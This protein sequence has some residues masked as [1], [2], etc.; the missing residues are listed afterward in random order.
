MIT[1]IQFP[2]GLGL[3]N[4]SPFCMKVETYLRMAGLQYEIRA[5]PDPRQAPKGKL[6][7]LEE[8]GRQIPDS[9]FI[10]RHLQSAH[11]HPME[12]GVRDADRAVAHAF[13]RM[14]EERFYWAV[15]YSRWLDDATWPQ[16]RTR[17]FRSL[18]PVLRQLLPPVVRRQVRRDLRGQGLGRHSQAEI[19]G[20]AEDDLRAV[21]VFLDNKPFFLGEAPTS[22]D[23]IVYSFLATA[24]HA[25]LDTPLRRAG[26]AFPNLVAYCDRMRE[27]YFSDLE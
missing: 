17:F 8:D 4:P 12:D 2:R 20:L 11:P 25:T 19:Y 21:S 7:V 27:R 24:I 23:A 15:V 1:L 13:A 16:L 22:T 18:P 3:P 5:T 26:R 9:A 14:L 10:L 6:P